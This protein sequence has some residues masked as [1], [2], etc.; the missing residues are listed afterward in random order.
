MVKR[1][2]VSVSAGLIIAIA[3]LVLGCDQETG[4]RDRK[5]VPKITVEQEFSQAMGAAYQQA[6]EYFESGQTNEAVVVFDALLDDPRYAPW[7]EQIFAETLRVRLFA[8]HTDTVRERVLGA[9][10]NGTVACARTGLQILLPDLLVREGADAAFAFAITVEGTPDVDAELTRWVTEWRFFTA[11]TA[12][13]M[14]EVS[15]AL[16]V[17][18]AEFPAE[19]A[20]GALANA[21]EQLFAA[22][23]LDDIERLHEQAAATG[24][25]RETRTHLLIATAVRLAAGRALWDETQTLFTAAAALLPDASL[26]HLMNQVLPPARN[27][28]RADIVDACVEDVILRHGDKPAAAAQAARFWAESAMAANRAA[29]PERLAAMLG[30]AIPPRTV[31]DLFTR[32]FYDLIDD[33]AVLKALL[34]IANQLLVSAAEDTAKEIKAMRLDGAFVLEDYDLAESYLETGIPG[35]DETWHKMALYKVKAHRALKDNNPREAVAQ[36]RLFMSFIAGIAE[37]ETYDPS[38]G[39]Q[40]S[41]EVLLGRNAKRIADILETIPD[42]EAAAEARTEAADYYKKALA[43]ARDDESR[44]RIRTEAGDLLID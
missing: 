21:F 29:L 25:T 44:E 36:F 40:H 15:D 3:V 6:N 31:S 20:D 35:K 22:G 23:R 10:T 37:D 5:K 12:A 14:D 33:T 7:A 28:G 11:L 9:C 13:N 24:D 1:A 39:I 16:A 4:S 8:G 41:R 43:D 17:I 18:L 34:P 30:A 26:Q 42:A 38:T 32:F 19:S 2:C 27:A